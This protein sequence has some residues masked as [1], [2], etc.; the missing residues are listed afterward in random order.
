LLGGIIE[1][2]ELGWVP[3]MPLGIWAMVILHVSSET[4]APSGP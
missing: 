1:L 2:V 3:G 4:L